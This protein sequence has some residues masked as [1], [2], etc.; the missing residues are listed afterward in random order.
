[1]LYAPLVV[2]RLETQVVVLGLEAQ[3]AVALLK[4][5]HVRRAEGLLEL[6]DLLGA[7]LGRAAE[8]VRLRGGRGA[9]RD[10]AQEVG[11]LGLEL[12]CMAPGFAEN[13]LRL[14]LVG[15]WAGEY[16]LG[17]FV[18]TAGA[19]EACIQCRRLLEVECVAPAEYAV[20]D[21]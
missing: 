11:A 6:A 4:E 2:R 14:S 21:S 3:Q 18:S 15:V 5:V 1:M 7:L 13:V 17:L 10:A 8:A 20:G 12:V 9:R 16:G 19:I